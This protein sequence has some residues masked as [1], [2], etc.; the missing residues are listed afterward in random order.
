[1][2]VGVTL[3]LSADDGAVPGWADIRAFAAAAEDG[4]LDSVWVYDHLLFRFPG[5]PTEGIQEAWTVLSALAV[6]TGRIRLGSLVMCSSF[7]NPA[8]LAKMAAAADEIS[9]GRLILGLGAGWHEPEYRAFG[10]PF[11]HLA[12]RFEESLSIIVPLLRGESVD[13]RGSHVEALDAVLL[14]AVARPGGLP[15]LIAGKG[16]RMLRL[17]ARYADAY[18]TA[19]Y[20]RPTE[21]M[22]TLRTRLEEACATE[23]RDPAA[24]AFTCGVIL[25]FGPADD[26]HD[27]DKELVGDDEAVAA[28]LR[29]FRDAGVDHVICSLKHK[30]IANVERLA[31][32]VE[33]VRAG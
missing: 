18:N 6:A 22:A 4:G 12:S 31:A 1:M 3:P 9:G 15:I 28:G 19:W 27:P 29:A 7:R 21:R 30:S 23:G 5:E 14:P 20:G 33:R 25:G 11:D 10:Y 13:V 16:P 26:G 24:I 32:I 17:T 2:A 8:L